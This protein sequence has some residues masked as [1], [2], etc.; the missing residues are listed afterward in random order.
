MLQGA[1]LYF[2]IGFWDG[3]SPH[4]GGGL[5]L[6]N[7]ECRM[8][9][10][11][12]RYETSGTSELS[13][14]HSLIDI[15]HS[16]FFIFTILTKCGPTMRDIIDLIGRVFLAA[17]FIFEAFDT[18]L[19]MEKTKETMAQY[20]LTWHPDL[21][22]YAST[23]LLLLGGTLV[24]IGYRTYLGVVLLLCYWV[25]ITFIIHDF[26]NYPKDQLRLQ[27]ILFMK[28]IA[29]TGGLLML[30]GKG[31]GRYSIKRVLSTTRVK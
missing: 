7:V 30:A 22:V 6:L 11:E 3:L 17:I 18:I 27:S 26:W 23:F 24:L 10:S 29:I 28:N 8:S 16:K 2:K 15:R 4:D 5:F 21:M 14:R 13:D 20:G 12:C 25:P 31:S 1:I 9:I 19:Y